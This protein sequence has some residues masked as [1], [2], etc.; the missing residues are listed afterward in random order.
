MSDDRPRSAAELAARLRGLVVHAVGNLVDRH[1]PGFLLPRTWGGHP[2]EPDVAADL[3]FTLGHLH[4]GGVQELGGTPLPHALRTVLRHIDGRRTHTFFSYRVAETVARFGPWDRNELLGPLTDDERRNVA[5]ACDSSEWIPLLDEQILPLNYASVL[6]RCEAARDA[7][8]LPVEPGR[9]D[10]LLE[11]ARSVLAANPARFLDDSNHGVGRYDIYTA[12]VWLFTETMAERL[13]PLWSEGFA[14]AVDLVE[15]ALADDGTAV[16][17]GRSTGS[18]GGALTVELAAAALARGVGDDPRRWLAR[19]IRATDSMPRWFTNG[20][21]DAHRHRSPYEYRGPF[22]RLQLTLDLLGKLAWAANELDGLPGGGPEPVA[23]HELDS[24]LDRFIP[25]EQGSRAGVW[26]RRDRTGATVVPFVGATRSDY[27]AAPRAPG[28]YEVPVD[29]E[30]AC[31]VPMAWVGDRRMVPSGRPVTLEHRQGTVTATW[32]GLRSGAEL[33]PLPTDADVAGTVTGTWTAIGRA[34]EVRWDL[35]LRP[36]E[37]RPM[38]ALTHLVPERADRPLRVEWR[39]RGAEAT[40][41]RV[42]VDGMAEWRSFWSTASHVHQLDVTPVPR[43]TVVLTVE[44]KLR[45]ASSAHGHHYHR[46]LYG[47]LAGHVWDRPS[48]WGPLG[49]GSVDPDTVDLFHLHWPEWVAFDDEGTHRAVIED[50]S[51]RRVPVVWTAHNLTP[52]DRRPEVYDPIYRR[53]NEAAA[54][55]IHHSHVGRERF[56]ARYGPGGERTRHVVI[57]HGHF[58]GLWADHRPTRTEAEAALGLEPC[59]LRVGLVGAPRADKD[60]VGFLRAAARSSRA[61]L[62]VVCWSL[63]GEEVAEVPDDPRLAVAEPYVMVDDA[64]YALRLA[65]CDALALPFDPAG[66]MAATGTVF[67]AIGT[68]LPALCSTWDYLAEVLGDA[69]VVVG[70][71]PEEIAAALDALDADRLDVAR[72]VLLLRRDELVWDQVAARTLALFEDTLDLDAG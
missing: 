49:D 11:R 53:W 72:G 50:L 39:V 64:T 44:P 18:L 1:A 63:L 41:D 45:V 33:D 15:A 8:G 70:D 71:G 61:D 42:L 51:A 36:A 14:T 2:V 65:A 7:L 66:D 5:E 38:R 6:A 54:A 9:V 67:D 57:P 25:F 10:D 4:D 60:V 58:G 26:A 46:S 34:L 22:R 31:W 29:S 23:D 40:A 48:P 37:D 47:P 35:D 68:G 12:D 56:L 30:L 20:V 21:V 55:V 43:H 19:G 27:L 13:E 59:A 62:Q 32:D 3:V 16:A 52:H 17:W 24:P 69:A 28:R